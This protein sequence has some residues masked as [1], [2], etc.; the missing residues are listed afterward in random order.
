MTDDTSAF[1]FAR[2]EHYRA[3]AAAR[4]TQDEKWSQHSRDAYECEKR[5]RDI[6]ALYGH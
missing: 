1:W 4:K 2:A 5:A 3:L 6:I